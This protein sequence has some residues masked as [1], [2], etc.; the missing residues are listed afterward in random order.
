MKQSVLF[1][2]LC[3]FFVG[4]LFAQQ[5]RLPVTT[6]DATAKALYHQALDA[7]DDYDM[8]TYYSLMAQ[9][10]ET[11]ADFFSA[12]ANLAMNSWAMGNKEGFQAY[13]K[14]ALAIDADLNPAER[15]MKQMITTLNSGNTDADLSSLGK[16]LSAAYPNV[17]EAHLIDGYLQMQ[18]ENTD[19]A[20]Q[21]FEKIVQ[22]KPDFGPAHNMLGYGN[23][24]A[25]EME[26]AKM[27]F[28]RY[29]ASN[30]DKP[31][32]HDSMGDY[33]MQAKDY[34]SAAKHGSG[35]N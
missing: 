22:L 33:Y 3:L 35:S 32:P 1:S 6:D 19:A 24:Q 34:G 20:L 16:Q 31:N 2:I 17:V 28:D 5:V 4:N 23:M 11:D 14:Q 30:P 13:A 10:A 15:I 8:N 7:A 9:A 12:R 26:K 25:G 18:A 21:S 27:H 29:I